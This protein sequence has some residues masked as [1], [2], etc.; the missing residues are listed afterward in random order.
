MAPIYSPNLIIGAGP[1]GLA[2]AGRLRNMNISFEIFEKSDKIAFT[3]HNHY[4]R[5]CLHTIRQLSGLPHMD[6]PEEYPLYVP[7]EDLVHYYE[8]YARHFDINP[9][10]NE[11]IIKVK[12]E[13][14]HWHIAT[15]SGKEY[16]SDHVIIATGV[17]RMP[18]SPSWEGQEKFQGSI[19]HSLTYKNPIPFEGKKVLI[20]GMGN[21][22]AELA[23]DLAENGID[24]AISV[25]S[26]INIVP[27][28]INGRSVQ[29]TAK[30]LDKIPLGLGNWLG[31]QIR[32]HVIGD[33]SKYGIPMSKMHPAV[34]LKETGKT[35][36]IDL[37]TVEYIKAGKIKILPDITHFSEEGISFVNGEEHNFDSVIL[38]TGYRA[39]LGDFIEGID[40][41]LD[42]Y[43]VPNQP[44]GEGK[45]K[46]LYFVGFD[47]YKLGGILGTI[48]NDSATVTQDISMRY[49]MLEG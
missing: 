31:T 27:R 15:K 29:M 34:Q 25:R 17:N 28:D 11:E 43:E 14:G 32:K 21:T 6:I 19:T 33:L 44:V 12:K 39:Q 46:G 5:L 45:F 26:P 7:R 8:E 23:L 37:G 3:W 36:V 24:V 41:F 30:T 9:H 35:P 49:G 16:T 2:T 42:T 4:D 1:A 10:F 22:G 13:D 20:I 38:A 47:N 40:G 48:Y 18:F